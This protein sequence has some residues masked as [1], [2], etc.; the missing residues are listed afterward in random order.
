VAL[1]GEKVVGELP[2][3]VR[4]LNVEAIGGEEG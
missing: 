2:G 3:R 1:G 4:K